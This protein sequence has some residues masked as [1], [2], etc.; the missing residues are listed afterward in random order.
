MK[1]RRFTLIE[2]LVVIAIIAILA[3]MLL[4]ALQRA[5]VSAQVGTCKNNMKQMAQGM[6][7]YAGDFNA[8]LP[9]HKGLPV[10]SNGFSGSG[11]RYQSTYWMLYLVERYGFG[12]KIFACPYNGHNPVSDNSAGWILGIGAGALKD[13]CLT[14]SSRTYYST[15]G[16]LLMGKDQWGKVGVS[17]KL[18][19]CDA[20]GKSVLILEYTLPTFVD[21]VSSITGTSSRK[22]TSTNSVRDHYGASS[23][24]AMLDG[25][26]EGLKYMENP[27]KIFVVP[28]R[29]M[30]VPTDWYWG[31][32]WQKPL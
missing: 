15:N 29:S 28:Q 1:K 11:I 20:P 12:A 23:N 18:S 6:Q 17:G 16:R 26:V 30:L 3:A 7:L 9:T 13:W 27:N 25:H 2:L 5:R 32:V 8:Q 22:A 19:R 24:F 10:P 31:T 21:G 14:D 4:P